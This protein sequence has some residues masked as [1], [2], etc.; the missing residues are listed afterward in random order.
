MPNTIEMRRKGW[1]PYSARTL[2]QKRLSN[3]FAEEIQTFSKV[4][5]GSV[6]EPEIV[7]LDVLARQTTDD[8]KA[9]PRLWQLSGSCVG[10]G[11][12]R[13]YSLAM[14][15]DVVFRQDIETVKIPS[16]WP[17]YG[18]GR[19]IAGMNGPGEGSFGAAQ[20]QACK[21]DE[22]GML[23]FD[24]P[25][26]P[27]PTIIDGWAKWTSVLEIK[28]SHPSSWP[29]KRATLEPDAKPFGVHAVT[30]IKTVEEMVQAL[31]QGYAITL[32]SMFGTKRSVVKGD[33]ALADWSDDWAHQMAGS[34][35]WVHPTHGLLIGIDNS[36][37]KSE[38]IHTPCPTLSKL[39]IN[40]SF[41][42]LA[43]T[44]QKILDSNDAEVF[45]H[46]ATGGF[47]KQSFDWGNMGWSFI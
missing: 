1:I 12:A 47:P 45:C 2:K 30:Q 24:D 42:I 32:A 5:R 34:F 18:V 46:S 39:G 3:E 14:A 4:M 13:A 15:G 37:G 21:P 27:Q 36:W 40:G 11:G 44:M 10:V 38:D 28:W 22:F 31:A 25:R 8:K 19:E 7:I 41:W 17:T 26:L 43:K 29:I 9:L 33:V 6:T 16:P 20:A 35:Y 23:P